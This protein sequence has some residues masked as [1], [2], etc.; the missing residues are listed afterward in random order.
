M[1]HP[2]RKL[3]LFLL[4]LLVGAPP[5]LQAESRPPSSRDFT[6]LLSNDDGYNAPGLQALIR[7]LQP[8]GE[9][10][11]AA[12]AD[13]QSGKGHSI[14]V[15]RP[16]YANLER[17]T[18]GDAFYAIQATPATCVRLALDALIPRKPDVVISGINRGDNLGL[19]VYYSGTVG[20]AREAAFSGVPAIAVSM[21]GDDSKDYA[22]AAAYA[23]ASTTL[24]SQGVT[25]WWLDVETGN[26][27]SSSQA[28]NSSAMR[29]RSKPCVDSATVT[30]ASAQAWSTAASISA[31]CSAPTASSSPTRAASSSY[32]GCGGS[33]IPEPNHDHKAGASTDTPQ[34]I[35]G[36]D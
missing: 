26:S 36:R 15:G 17:Q 35:W 16:I 10:F 34:I 7:A 27:W 18:Q 5:H 31:A 12:P 33:G 13:N 9:L 22:A 24:G 11:V 8:A 25:G 4:I 3:L 20:A 30:C 23:Y 1:V 2:R 6:I 28:A 19:L 14:S 21:Q 29:R 32:D